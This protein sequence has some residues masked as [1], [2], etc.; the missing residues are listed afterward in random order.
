M[1]RF[2]QTVDCQSFTACSAAARAERAA[3]PRRHG[4]ATA[5]ARPAAA[6]SARGSTRRARRCRQPAR[7]QCRFLDQRAANGAAVGTIA[8]APAG[9]PRRPA[10]AAPRG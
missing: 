5:A 6:S 4:P 2:S 1:V 3:P 10:S 7:Y 9:W 8:W